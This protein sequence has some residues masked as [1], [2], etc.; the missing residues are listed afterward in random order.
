VC[1]GL[2]PLT[3]IDLIP[4]SQELRVSFK[5]EARAKEMKKLHKQVR[6]QIKSNTSKSPTRIA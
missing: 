3:L 2:S 4:I 5:A 6:A 1:N